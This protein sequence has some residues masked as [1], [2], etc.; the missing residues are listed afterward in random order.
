[1][2][3]PDLAA[4]LSLAGHELRG[5]AGV[6]GG[7]LKL[8]AR[9]RDTMPS[10]QQQAVDASARTLA[11]LVDIL[12]E[13]RELQR[14]LLPEPTQAPVTAPVDLADLVREVAARPRDAAS[15]RLP[16]TL[17]PVWWTGDREALARALDAC[18]DAVARE[19]L[20]PVTVTIALRTD[21][22][23]AAIRLTAVNGA[24]ARRP[25]DARRS[26]LGLRL[27]LAVVVVEAGG[28]RLYDLT[29]EGT[30]AGIELVLPLGAG[31]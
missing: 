14:W 16:A 30:P 13:L 23:D 21:G 8:L 5:P 4:L 17:P 22:P 31:R 28:G 1:M 11:R 20:P 27:V 25:L 6:L 10:R 7:Y 15:T 29:V 18:L 24:W 3:P 2:P 9:E 26:G 12:D 19:H